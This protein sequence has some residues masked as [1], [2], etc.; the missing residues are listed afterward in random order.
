MKNLFRTFK[1]TKP[2]T[3]AF[4]TYAVSAY[5][6][7]AI[8]TAIP[9]GSKIFGEMKTKGDKKVLIINPAEQKITIL[10]SKNNKPVTSLLE[11]P[12]EN[13]KKVYPWWLLLVL[14]ALIGG[15]IFTYKKLKK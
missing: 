3:V 6:S 12:F 14:L 8:T 13:V 15:G 2:T 9:E 10:D 4:D 11:I 5:I 7:N 1:V